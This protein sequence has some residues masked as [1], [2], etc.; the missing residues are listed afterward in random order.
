M[1]NQPFFTKDR[2]HD[3]FIPTP[4]ANGPW[5]PNSLHGRVIIDLLAFEIE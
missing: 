1:K 5:D 4:F 3:A 2:V